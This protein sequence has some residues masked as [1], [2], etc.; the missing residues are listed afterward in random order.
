MPRTTVGILRMFNLGALILV[1]TGAKGRQKEATQ[2]PN[3]DL[4]LLLDE[5]WLVSSQTI[6]RLI[7]CPPVACD[8]KCKQAPTSRSNKPCLQHDANILHD[9]INEF[10]IGRR[11]NNKIE[12]C[13]L[14]VSDTHKPFI[15]VPSIPVS[16]EC[17]ALGLP[18]GR[19]FCCAFYKCVP[20]AQLSH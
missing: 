6:N 12:K 16:L 2:A 9:N 11:F 7:V 10:K 3:D 5:T 19:L 4:Q 8:G 14:K 15:L 13:V 20:S 17:Q 18:A 1:A